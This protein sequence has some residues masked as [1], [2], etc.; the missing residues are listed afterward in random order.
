M[1]AWEPGGRRAMSKATVEKVPQVHGKSS[2]LM[3]ELMDVTSEEGMCGWEKLWTARYVPGLVVLGTRDKGDD[4][5]GPSAR[6]SWFQL[7]GPM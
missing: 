1:E 7:N 5:K 3:W 2:Q 6:S 4:W